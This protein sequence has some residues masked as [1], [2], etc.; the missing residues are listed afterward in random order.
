[1]KSLSFF[2]SV[3][4]VGVIEEGAGDREMLSR[5]IHCGD[6]EK[7]GSSEEADII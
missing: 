2:E 3:L 5:M 4:I 1:M 6:S 7:I